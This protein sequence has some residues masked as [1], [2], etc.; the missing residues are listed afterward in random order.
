MSGGREIAAARV[1]ALRAARAQGCTCEPEVRFV[2][3]QPPLATLAHDE[4]CPL[5]RTMQE[6]PPGA[7]RSQAVIYPKGSA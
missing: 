4:W 3:G 2:N 5:L 6:R 1:A 7:A